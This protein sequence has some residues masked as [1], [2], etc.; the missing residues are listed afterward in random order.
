MEEVKTMKRILIITILA[1]LLLSAVATTAA[2]AAKQKTVLTGKLYASNTDASVA[3]PVV[4]TIT[5][6][7][8]TGA[9]TITQKNKATLPPS[10]DGTYALGITTTRPVHGLSQ[11]GGYQLTGW[12]LIVQPDG[13]I[14]QTGTLSSQSID[15][16]KVCLPNG[17]VFIFMAYS[18]S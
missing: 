11:G 10:E 8:E 5:L 15:T 9:W 1:V 2:V 3:E 4:G 13:T 7:T 16:V 14:S 17:G 18:A 12:E 6:N